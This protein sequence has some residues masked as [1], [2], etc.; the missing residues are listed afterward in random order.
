MGQWLI[1]LPISI[2]WTFIFDG[3]I[4]GIWLGSAIGNGFIVALY[5]RL[6]IKADWEKIGEEVI[7]RHMM[8]RSIS[9]KLVSAENHV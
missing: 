1:G 2:V 4:Q 8:K 6:V 9:R 5:L 7:E 3:G